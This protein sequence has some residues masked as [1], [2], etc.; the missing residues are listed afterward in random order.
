MSAIELKALEREIYD[1]KLKQEQLE[2]KYKL[3]QNLLVLKLKQE[4]SSPKAKK[5]E[6]W[7]F[8][9]LDCN[10]DHLRLCEHCQSYYCDQ[11]QAFRSCFTC[12]TVHVNFC[13]NCRWF[14]PKL[15]EHKHPK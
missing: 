15:C 7:C 1:L 12:D 10:P 11:H 14:D 4:N 2:A 9:Q 5:S 6:K 3:K 13:G 8:A